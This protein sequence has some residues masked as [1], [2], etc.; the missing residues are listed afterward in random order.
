MG[1]RFVCPNGH[2]LN[3][4]TFLAGK[5]GICPDCDAK[6]IVPAVSGGLAV[7]VE[8]A[9][10]LPSSTL[11]SAH[12]P[13]VAVSVEP[14]PVGPTPAGPEDSLP[15]T[16]EQSLPDS[17]YVRPV[18]GEQYGPAG[19]DLMQAW[20][21]EGRVA[22]DSWVWRTG[23]EQWK[24]AC[25]VFEMLKP[26]PPQDTRDTTTAP[27]ASVAPH[28]PHVHIDQHSL[29]D[30]HRAEKPFAIQ[31]GKLRPSSRK[32]RTR[33]VAV[34]LGTLVLVLAVALVLV[35]WYQN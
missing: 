19:T 3:V 31:P 1:I 4:K 28:A 9:R 23:W 7:L 26:A 32:E 5:R 25:E 34:A 16:I 18:S 11:A 30:Q 13:E 22:G 15:A 12:A 21:A 29:I 35:L 33:K 27:A 20:V 6:F 2:K 8:P 14:P 24:I 10:E 17:W